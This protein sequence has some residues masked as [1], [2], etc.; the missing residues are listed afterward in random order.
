MIWSVEVVVGD[1]VISPE[2]DYPTAFLLVKL[3]PV[4]YIFLDQVRIHADH[5]P[6][7]VDV[8]LSVSDLVLREQVDSLVVH[9]EFACLEER[10]HV[11][12]QSHLC[13]DG[14]LVPVVEV[15][16]RVFDILLEVLDALLVLVLCAE[17]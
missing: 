7:Q 15:D 17:K 8:H 9:L 4:S 1:S 5:P 3:L 13:D 16:N 14:E 12:I 6:E 10:D 11:G 2:T